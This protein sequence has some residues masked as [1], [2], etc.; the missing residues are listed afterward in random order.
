MFKGSQ[1]IIFKQC[2]CNGG[3]RGDHEVAR[4]GRPT[5]LLQV[6]N[7]GAFDHPSHAPELRDL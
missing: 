4:E 2:T 3:P 7:Y 5:K 1:Y 6:L